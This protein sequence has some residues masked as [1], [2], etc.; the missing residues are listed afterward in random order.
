MRD[1]KLKLG[2]GQVGCRAWLL[3]SLSQWFV[4]EMRELASALVS[5]DHCTEQDSVC[6][7]GFEHVFQ[8]REGKINRKE[9]LKKSSFFL[10]S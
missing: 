1:Q 4:Y 9:I 8:N 7:L 2:R 5:F 3:G 6:L 10:F